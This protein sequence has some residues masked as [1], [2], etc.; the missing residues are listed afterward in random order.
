MNILGLFSDFKDNKQTE[1]LE[2]WSTDYGIHLNGSY[3]CITNEKLGKEYLYSDCT[4]N[5]YWAIT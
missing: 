1:R 3:V 2:A 5:F 4:H